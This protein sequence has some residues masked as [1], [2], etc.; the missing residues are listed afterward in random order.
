MD[1][2]PQFASEMFTEC[3][4]EGRNH[5]TCRCDL[6]CWYNTA[7]VMGSLSYVRAL[8]HCPIVN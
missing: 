8:L 7:Q 1:V 2:P 6:V 5:C 4:S 3:F